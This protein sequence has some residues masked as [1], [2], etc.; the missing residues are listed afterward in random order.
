VRLLTTSDGK[1]LATFA[2]ATQPQSVAFSPDGRLLATGETSGTV[3]FWDL[4]RSAESGPPL[5]HNRDV[6]SI[7]FSPDGRQ[8]VTGSSDQTARVWNVEQR[9]A[10][11]RPMRHSSRVTVAAFSP[12]AR[13]I[14]TASEDHTARV[15]DAA[16]GHPVTDALR[17]GNRVVDA[18]WAPDGRSVVTASWDGSARI[19]SL[20]LNPV[21]RPDSARLATLAENF[22][23]LRLTDEDV[24]LKLIGARDP[25]TVLGRP[26]AP[27][28]NHLP[29]WEEW[30]LADR[31]TRG[32]AP[33]FGLTP[34]EFMQTRLDETRAERLHEALRL[35][36]M[37]AEGLARWSRLV[38]RQN[39]ERNR[40]RLG[41]AAFAAE[42]AVQ[43]APESF[44]A[45]W[46]LAEV[47]LSAGERDRAREALL[48]AVD[49]L[50]VEIS[51]GDRQAFNLL[52]NRLGNVAR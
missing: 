22:G 37:H 31:A 30:L 14:L 28:P 52:R 27:G 32:I 49:R 35:A 2:L 12:D 8:L 13:H 42:L 46:S 47:R 20:P 24:T 25:G 34:R 7:Q 18:A 43:L 9:R 45:W 6:A 50:P 41:E 29:A 15:W 38:L 36:P 33:G 39:P 40:R 5:Q 17:H 48:R 23:R 11:S 44:E 4:A 3:R 21:V 51:A 16:T 1:L 26:P 19:W 10:R